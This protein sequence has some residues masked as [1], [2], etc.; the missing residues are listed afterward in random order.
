MLIIIT[1]PDFTDFIDDFR[2]KCPVDFTEIPVSH[3]DGNEVIQFC[4]QTGLVGAAIAALT[5]ILGKYWE[6]KRIKV[7]VDGLEYE[8]PAKEVDKFLSLAAK[9]EEVKDGADE[10]LE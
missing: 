3:F 5:A 1:E 10:K 9:H 4:I 7:K 6:S 2:S 8:G